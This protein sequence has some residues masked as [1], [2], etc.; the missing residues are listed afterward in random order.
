[1]LLML[2]LNVIDVFI[3]GR[4]GDDYNV[5]SVNDDD[6]D[7]A[8]CGRNSPCCSV[9]RTS[10]SRSSTTGSSWPWSLTVS[11]FTSSHSRLGSSGW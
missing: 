5:G 2:L 11:S 7:T 8:T 4:R 3:D 10:R 6:D 1:M 9:V